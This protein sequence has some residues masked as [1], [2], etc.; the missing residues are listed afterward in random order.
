MMGSWVY[1]ISSPRRAAA[2]GLNQSLGFVRYE[3][4]CYVWEVMPEIL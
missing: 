1:L 4:N 2:N 3:T